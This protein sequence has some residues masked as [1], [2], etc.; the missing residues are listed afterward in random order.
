MTCAVDSR[1]TPARRLYEKHGF[2]RFSD[3][4]ALVRHVS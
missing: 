2:R 3:R 1:N 4:I